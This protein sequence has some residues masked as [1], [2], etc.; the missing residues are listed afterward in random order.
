VYFAATGFGNKLAGSI[1]ESSQL[2]PF[3]G[4]M[5]VNKEE[6][7]PFIQKDTIKLRDKN[8]KVLKVYDYPI[9]E[10][11]NFSIKSQVYLYNGEVIFKEMGTGRPLN[12]L[13]EIDSENDKNLA[14]LKNV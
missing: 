1:G 8:F 9:N 5:V 12:D 10:D 11:K 3:S 7:L 6:I 4:E 13:F 2:T 14:A